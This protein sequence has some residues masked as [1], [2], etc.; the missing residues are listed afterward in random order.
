LS[1]YEAIFAG[2]ARDYRRGG[3]D[4]LVNIT[5]DAWYGR[6]AG[7]YQHA[8]HLV[9]RAIETRMGVARA[10]NSG[11]SETVDPLGYAHDATNLEVRTAEASRLVT[12]DRSEEHTSELQSR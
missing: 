11:I 9:M 8:S 6:T 12:S 4:F 3:A 2:L 7:P 1:C 5:N 10:A